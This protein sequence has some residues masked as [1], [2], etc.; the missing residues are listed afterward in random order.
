MKKPT[1]SNSFES[2]SSNSQ[3]LVSSR[4]FISLSSISSN[5]SI[6]F[7]VLLSKSFLDFVIILGIELNIDCRLLSR[8]SKA[9]AFTKP[10]NCNLLISF[11]S[12]LLIKSF[13]E[14]KF[15]FL[16]FLLLYLILLQI[17]LLWCHLVRKK[18]FRFQF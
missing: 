13:I 5:K 15:H 1:D 6:W 8:L 17:L 2:L 11:G 7:A 14:I 3:S 18:I 4:I 16:F 9:P 10:S 12:T